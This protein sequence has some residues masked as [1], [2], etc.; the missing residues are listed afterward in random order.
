MK[1][2]QL[3][4][5]TYC[6][7]FHFLRNR[8][9]NGVSMSQNTSPITTCVHSTYRVQQACHHRCSPLVSPLESTSTVWQTLAAATVI[10]TLWITAV[11]SAGCRI[12][13]L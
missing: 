3:P 13:A 4:L 2:R 12:G 8:S 9:N 10:L 1:S 5:A 6:K 11:T 7:A